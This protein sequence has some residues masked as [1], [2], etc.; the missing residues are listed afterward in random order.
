MESSSIDS[1]GRSIELGKDATRRATERVQIVA[2]AIARD[3]ARE[4]F[5][6]RPGPLCRFCAFAA[7]CPATR[8]GEAGAALSALLDLMRSEQGATL[9][10]TSA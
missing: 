4:D 1:P 9:V 5:A 7:F 3:F 10:T 6:P 2:A 8:R